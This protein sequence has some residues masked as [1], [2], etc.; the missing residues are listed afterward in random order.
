MIVN[1][2]KVNVSNGTS[3]QEFLISSKYDPS[4]VAVELNGKISSRK[5]FEEVMLKDTD[6]M[7]IVS[8]VGGG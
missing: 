8:F 6:S 7:E 2:K 4:R 5:T 3:L 1:G